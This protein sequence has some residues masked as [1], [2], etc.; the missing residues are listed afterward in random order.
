[1]VPFGATYMVGVLQLLQS[2]GVRALDR[3]ET[4]TSFGNVWLPW[5]RDA[6]KTQ[7]L[8]SG[9][10]TLL[11]VGCLTIL[12][13]FWTIRRRRAPQ[14]PSAETS[15]AARVTSSDE[16][17][18]S[19]A[20]RRPTDA[21]PVLRVPAHVAVQASVVSENGS[22]ILHDGLVAFRFTCS[23]APSPQDDRLRRDRA[24][25]LARLL[26]SDPKHKP[27]K[28]GSTLVISIPIDT[29]HCPYQRY[30]LYLLATY[31]NLFV[32]LVQSSTD[33]PSVQQQRRVDA[34]MA[35]RG[36]AQN[37]SGDDG[38]DAEGCYLSASIL[39]THRILASM[40]VSGRVAICRQL[41]SVD[42]ILD[43]EAEVQGLLSR[44]GHVVILYHQGQRDAASN[45][46]R[47]EFGK[48]LL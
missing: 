32:I 1:M 41:Q 5:L 45:A 25:L 48:L 29:V 19:S 13:Y 40:T 21:S 43:Y 27:P 20:V 37:A 36:D 2:V 42:V 11:L 30:G 15:V 38:N 33:P 22:N 4:A 39:P 14:Q 17:Y 34:V 23:A 8:Y 18:S 10:L 12:F 46:V 26:G 44:F 6:V 9:T 31:F 3:K 47:S 24:Q 16:N 35:L 7:N 28:K